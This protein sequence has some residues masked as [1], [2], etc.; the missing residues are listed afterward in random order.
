MIANP[1]KPSAGTRLTVAEYHALMAAGVMTEYDN[2]ELIHEALVEKEML[3]PPHAAGVTRVDHWLRLRAGAAVLVRV[4]QPVTLADSEP[5]PD[6]ALVLPRRDFYATGHPKP[7]DTFLVV[8]VADSSFPSDRDVKGPLY[9]E[10]A[11]PEY[12]IVDLNSD[13]VLVYRKPRPDG[14]WADKSTHGR[15]DTLAVAALPGVS[16]A[17]ADLL[18]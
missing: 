10:N 16:V 6:V 7:P 14:T 12:W 18:P 15:G 5:E 3:N 9:A 11:I 17:V 13:T 2:F 8:E 4:Q 1:Q